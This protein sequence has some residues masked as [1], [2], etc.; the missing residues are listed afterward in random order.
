[1]AWTRRLSLV[2]FL[3]ALLVGAV[4]A[5]ATSTFATIEVRLVP[6][7]PSG[8]PTLAV[9]GGDRS[10]EV[11]PT[12]LLDPSDFAAVGEVEVTGGAP[13]FLVTLTL[14]GAQKYERITR[15]NV[16]RTMAIIA[17]GRVIMTP[18]ILE[19]V[20]AP[21]FQLSMRSETEARALAAEMRKA[22]AAQ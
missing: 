8:G 18:R 19:P 10:L 12:V 9:A 5:Q 21:G 16:G 14:A 13:H 11:E 22:I 7:Q 15:E 20:R 6:Q 1:M 17:G 2:P 4:P 3:I